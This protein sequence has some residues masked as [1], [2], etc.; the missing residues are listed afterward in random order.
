MTPRR[1]A[2]APRS[3]VVLGLLAAL[4]AGCSAP[5][6]V[7]VPAA[8]VQIDAGRG[9]ASVTG[10]GVEL[11][12]RP[13]AWHGNPWDLRDYVTPFLVTLSNAAGA[14]VEYDYGGFRLFD[15]ARFQYT[16]LPPT[17]VVRIMR[18]RA[19]WLVSRLCF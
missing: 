5:R 4:V 16:A 7:P 13:L 2:A 8:G 19:K 12:V 17:E 11:A 9:R 3:C 14:P 6:I 1:G 18:W 15:D 10:D